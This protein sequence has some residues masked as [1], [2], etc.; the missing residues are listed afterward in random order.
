MGLME[1]FNSWD[2][3]K[4]DPIYQLAEGGQIYQLARENSNTNWDSWD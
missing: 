2:D 4:M 3:T 1:Q